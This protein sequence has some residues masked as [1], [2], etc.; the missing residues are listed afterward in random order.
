M[1]EK[2]VKPYSEY[3][4]IWISLVLLTGLTVTAASLHLGIWT[5]AAAMSIAIMKSML[6][7]LHF[8]NLLHEQRIFTFMLMMTLVTFAVILFLTFIDVALR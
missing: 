2:K 1:L 5:I 8:M 6:V 3:L 4:L 7:L